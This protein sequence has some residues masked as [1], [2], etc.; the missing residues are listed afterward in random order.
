M[1]RVTKNV[2]VEI[3][4]Q[5]I[6]EGLRNSST[7]CAVSLAIKRALNKI[8]PLLVDIYVTSTATWAAVLVD[9]GE[10]VGKLRAQAVWGHTDTLAAWIR[11]FDRGEKVKPIVTIIRGT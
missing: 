6:D 4:Q 5:D 7:K 2:R 10:T 1:K 9:D 11:K 3:T 8:D